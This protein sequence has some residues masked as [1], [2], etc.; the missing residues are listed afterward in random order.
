MRPRM[1]HQV[2]ALLIL[3]VVGIGL[4]AL[5]LAAGA[6][7]D[8]TTII[9]D[10]AQSYDAA[11]NVVC[12]PSC[13]TPRANSPS[14]LIA[15]DSA[16]ATTSPVWGQPAVFRST[17]RSGPGFDAGDG[18]HHL[19]QC[20]VGMLRE[21]HQTNRRIAPRTAPHL[22]PVAE[23]HFEQIFTGK[24]WSVPLHSRPSDTAAV[25]R[26]LR[27][28]LCGSSACDVQYDP[29]RARSAARF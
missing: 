1:R 8:A 26:L 7:A 29:A 6:A 10:C 12:R 11:Y 28:V 24:P 13:V 23:R 4:P 18:P 16:Q 5:G 14:D 19:Q 22:I 25:I 27:E 17:R 15:I 21:S 20:D 3:D 2:L 9:W